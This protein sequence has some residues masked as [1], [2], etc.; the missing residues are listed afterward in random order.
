MLTRD[1][2]RMSRTALHWTIKDLAKHAGITPQTV[3]K[4]ENG[5]NITVA[6]TFYGGYLGNGVR[7]SSQTGTTVNNSGDINVDAWYSY[8]IYASTGAGNTA[9][10]NTVDGTVL[11]Y[12][13]GFAIGAI[14]LSNTGDV[15]IDNAGVIG[16]MAYGE[17]VA[18]FVSR[19]RIWRANSP[20]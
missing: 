6:S 16:T 17:S 10:T 3:T 20:K 11:A 4:F 19:L 12:G 13:Q 7:A 9:I 2:V 8:G 5:G 14:G 18:S 15:S 1:Q